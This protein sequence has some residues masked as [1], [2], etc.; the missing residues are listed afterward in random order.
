M[1]ENL[2]VWLVTFTAVF[3][4]AYAAMT[5]IA[6]ATGLNDAP[7]VVQIPAGIAVAAVATWAANRASRMDRFNQ[8]KEN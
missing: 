7:T 1:R 3:A 8:P 4:A 5:V 2:P 6:D